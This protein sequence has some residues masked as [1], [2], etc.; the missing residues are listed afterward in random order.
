MDD[1]S[2]SPMM[3]VMASLWKSPSSRR[4]LDEARVFYHSLELLIEE[5]FENI[6]LFESPH[7][8]RHLLDPVVEP[9]RV[10]I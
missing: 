6:T 8:R 5:V 2:A 7:E 3:A 4:T 1:F 9:V 10:G